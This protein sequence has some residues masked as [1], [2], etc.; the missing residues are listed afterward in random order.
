MVKLETVENL[1]EKIIVCKQPS[2]GYFLIYH[3]GYKTYFKE[4]NLNLL[5]ILFIKF[6]TVCYSDAAKSD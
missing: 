1:G 3:A 4:V 2:M 5:I 6:N